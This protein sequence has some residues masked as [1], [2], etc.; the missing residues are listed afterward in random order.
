MDVKLETKN[1]GMKLIPFPDFN[2]LGSYHFIQLHPGRIL[3]DSFTPDLL[4]KTT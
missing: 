3:W 2:Y 1:K 4:S